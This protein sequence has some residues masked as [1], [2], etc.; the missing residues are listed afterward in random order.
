MGSNGGNPRVVETE[1]V[2][3]NGPDS[4][5]IA[6]GL[7]PLMSRKSCFGDGASTEAPS[8]RVLA[9]EE[10]VE[11][12]SEM[13]GGMVDSDRQ[14][15]DSI[16]PQELEPQNRHLSGPRPPRTQF[17]QI[18]DIAV[19]G[20]SPSALPRT[21]SRIFD[22]DDGFQEVEGNT[23][24]VE[25]TAGEESKG[26]GLILDV[27]GD[28]ARVA[29][30]RQGGLLS[31]WNYRCAQAEI[32]RRGDLLLAVDGVAMGPM[33]L[34]AALNSRITGPVRLTFAY[35]QCAD[36]LPPDGSPRA[37][38]CEADSFLV[39]V[40]CRHLPGD[41]ESDDEGFEPYGP[42]NRIRTEL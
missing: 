18:A 22:E 34:V 33:D 21:P 30:I 8:E 14:D 25:V 5:P 9:D 27:G 10:P 28:L 40:E 38:S 7:H 26:L 12:S 29:H 3:T 20:E 37:P 1:E 11:S 19:T 2:S 17:V 24:S 42:Y 23:F 15:A 39:P 36:R 35:A 41:H 16:V 6:G 13:P 32:V 4:W 31:R